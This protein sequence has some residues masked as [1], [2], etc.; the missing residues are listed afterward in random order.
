MDKIINPITGTEFLNFNPLETNEMYHASEGLS[1]SGLKKFAKTPKHFKVGK[2]YEETASQRLGTLGHMGVLEPARF[3]DK[4]KC[5]EGHRGA[6]AVKEV[7]AAAEAEGFY[8]CKEDEYE[9]AREMAESVAANKKTAAL[10]TGGIAEVS[11]RAIHP[12]YGFLMKCRPDYII[13]DKGIV[14]DLKTFTDLDTPNLEKQVAKQK[15]HWQSIFYLKVIEYALGIKTNMFA[16]VFI[17]TESKSARTVVLDDAALDKA[18]SEIE[19]LLAK[20][21]DCVHSDFWPGYP[22]EIETITLPSWAW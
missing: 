17:D 14:V 19:P 11:I 2:H 9:A 20:Y 8:V 16:H 18:L 1:F 13:L 21:A 10:L 22:E 12:V 6:K 3:R 7:I 15:Y 5:V 4:V